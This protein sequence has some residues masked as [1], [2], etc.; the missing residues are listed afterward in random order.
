VS[1]Y[2]LL[3]VDGTLLHGPSSERLF[4][5]HLVANGQCG[6]RQLAAAALFC[7]R[8]W[9]TY[10]RHVLKKNKAYLVGLEV[11]A[12]QQTAEAF[13]QQLLVTRIRPSILRR[14]EEHRR[15]GHPVAL[16]TGTPEFIAAP[17]AARL[18]A[19]AYS[20]MRCST[21]D[22]LFDGGPP[23]SH[24]FGAEKLQQ[25]QTLC[26]RLGWRLSDCYA[27]ADSAHDIPLLRAA[28]H[29]I[30]VHPDRRLRRVAA[31]EGWEIMPS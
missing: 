24:P 10:G 7:L 14:L 13:V 12:V 15:A 11:R 28:G 31:N 16:L 4:F 25:A 5:R 30:A 17:L 29:P 22:G 3:D 6:W 26:A 21:R 27:Y 20:A 19:Q 1:R 18:H 9:P 2:V 8:W 23:T